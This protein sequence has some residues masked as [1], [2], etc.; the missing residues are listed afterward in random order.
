MASEPL[1]IPPALKP[2]AHYVK[3][4]Y[5]NESRDP[6]VHYWCLY[7]AVQTGMKVD[8]SPPSLQYLSSLLSILENSLIYKK[9]SQ[10]YQVERNLKQIINA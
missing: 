10:T 8:K 3:I 9:R 1:N 4:A 6:V 5:Q 2:I 7:Y